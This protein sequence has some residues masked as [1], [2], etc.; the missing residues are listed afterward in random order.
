MRTKKNIREW[1]KQEPDSL[2]EMP[3]EKRVRCWGAEARCWGS[4]AH[5]SCLEKELFAWIKR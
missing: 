1:Q 3:K 5:L 2:K 4:E